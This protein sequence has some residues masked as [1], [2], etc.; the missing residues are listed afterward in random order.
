MVIVLTIAVLLLL[1]A[2]PVV[3]SKLKFDGTAGA[4]YPSHRNAES[5]SEISV[6]S[7]ERIPF[8]APSTAQVN[9][10]DAQRR[11][12]GV[13]RCRWQDL[14]PHRWV[15]DRGSTDEATWVERDRS[16]TIE[17][18]VDG[19]LVDD[20]HSGWGVVETADDGLIAYTVADGVCRARGVPSGRRLIAVRTDESAKE[21]A[22]DTVVFVSGC[23]V[24]D[25]PIAQFAPKVFLG[26]TDTCVVTIRI[27]GQNRIMWVASA[28]VNY[29]P[30]Y[31]EVTFH[32]KD[33]R[34]GTGT[35]ND[36]EALERRAA[37][38]SRLVEVGALPA[39]ADE[40]FW[41]AVDRLP[42]GEDTGVGE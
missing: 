13:A 29:H 9:G 15:I 35:V 23:G 5:L 33:F 4:Q 39:G 21:V 6:A 11:S 20:R 27:I 26:V 3:I 14:G 24:S 1:V 16:S 12:H 7:R 31:G 25:I 38:W 34:P 22:S 40:P 19:F 30:S 17:L 32:S 28:I 42:V 36:L 37:L 8:R 41:A 18:E 10:P 2:M